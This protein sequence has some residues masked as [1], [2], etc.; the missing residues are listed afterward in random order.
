[1]HRWSLL[2]AVA[3]LLVSGCTAIPQKNAVKKIHICG[4]ENC[5]TADHQYSAGQLLTGFQQ[6]LKVNEGEKV[7]ICGS[8]AKTRACESVGVCQFVLGGIVP[9]NGCA[10]DIVFSE[11]A[12]GS[13]TG[14][15]SLKADM[16]LTFIWT[17][18]YCAPATAA[19]S[20]H[21]ADEI[22]LEFQ[23]RFCSW[24]A[25][26]PM[27]ATFN[28]AIESIDLNHGQI[29]G[30][31][32]HAVKG[33]GNGRG[34]GYLVMKFPKAMPSGENWFAGQPLHPPSR[35]QLSGEEP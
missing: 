23:P 29:G 14:Q 22:S 24:M 4:A 35:A 20:V 34:S 11:I 27:V 2:A 16:P 12:M 7:A 13:Q 25:V 6:L 28:F 30:Y 9:G 26:G 15:L 18:V 1:M 33:G 3:A 5:D 19:L 32:S 8:N 17:P 31:W 10:K 21:S